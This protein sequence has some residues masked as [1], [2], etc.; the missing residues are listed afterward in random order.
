M[1]DPVTRSMPEVEIRTLHQKVVDTKSSGTARYYTA[2]L[3]RLEAY[4]G[5]GI[6]DLNKVDAAYVAEFGAYLVR[7]GVTLSTVKLFK[8]ALR[9]VMKDAF[10]PECRAQFKSA[11]KEVGSKN[12]APTNC[13]SYE[14]LDR[15]IGCNLDG[16]AVLEKARLVFLYCLVS[17]GLD[18]K[19]LKNR[20]ESNTID[21]SL[22]QQD[23]ILRN[24]ERSFGCSFIHY[25][26]KLS[27]AHYAQAVAQIGLSAGLSVALKPQSV[28]DGWVLA[29][30]KARV[31][32]E[33]MAAV[34]PPGSSFAA[35]VPRAARL[36][37]AERMKA[38]RMTA[39]VVID[40]KPR[41][42][43][44]KCYNR[45]PAEMEQIIRGTG[46][47]GEKD[48]FSSFIL[49][50]PQAPRKKSAV[51]R[52]I[53]SD[54][55]FFNCTPAAAVSIR[56]SVRNDARVYTLYGTSVPAQI[57]NVEMRTFMLLCDVSD[58]TL[59][60]HFPEAGP[61]DPEMAVG[62]QAR[63][64]SGSLSGLVGVISEVPNNRN[65]YKV[66]MSFTSLCATITAEVPV[67]FIKFV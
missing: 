9:A 59:S 56:K 10:G 49:P 45:E 7:S 27:E 28:V 16:L 55:F 32:V 38:L 47:I 6:V 53:L 18:Y 43:A 31:P 60:Y 39:D 48:R 33:V 37:D 40:M 21:R 65:K 64:V 41:W 44:M 52:P 34:L 51:K 61:S 8:M 1:I 63:V 67:E 5:S 26:S 24:F 66:V 54:L 42:Y 36:T 46:I 19:D 20:A 13:I 23:L 50:K 35:H 3:K 4:N 15:I 58:G 2:M 29:A 11:F 30:G 25:V 17:G 57:S 12:E 22:P 14:E 62:R